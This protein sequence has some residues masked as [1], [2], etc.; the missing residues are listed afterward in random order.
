MLYQIINTNVLIF[1]EGLRADLREAPGAKHR[2]ESGA[3]FGRR[4]EAEL[5]EIQIQIGGAGDAR[6][7]DA[8]AD[9]REVARG[10]PDPRV[11]AV[12]GEHGGGEGGV[13]GGF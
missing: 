4:R 6:G 12:G 10:F 7:A 5:P 9:H 2:Q 11:G 3:H 8:V 1:H 13:A